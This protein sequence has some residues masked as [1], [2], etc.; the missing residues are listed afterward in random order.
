MTEDS[1][2]FVNLIFFNFIQL[3]PLPLRAPGPEERGRDD[4]VGPGPPH[5]AEKRALELGRVLEYHVGI[6]RDTSSY[7]ISV[8]Y[9]EYHVGIYYLTFYP[10]F[11]MTAG[12]TFC[13]I[14]SSFFEVVDCAQPGSRNF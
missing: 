5:H 13:R 8:G 9:V 6:R 4:F 11:S 1:E 2:N 7:I 10:G 12:R 3:C 14:F